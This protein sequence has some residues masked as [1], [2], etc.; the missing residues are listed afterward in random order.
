[1]SI[2]NSM[3][4]KPAM[5]S[6]MTIIGLLLLSPFIDVKAQKV[7]Q[8]KILYLLID[9]NFEHFFTQDS[10]VLVYKPKYLDKDG[11]GERTPSIHG[12]IVPNGRYLLKSEIV[13]SSVPT[14][15]SLLETYR[16][17]FYK[18]F[19]LLLLYQNG[20]KLRIYENTTCIACGE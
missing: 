4:P 13:F 14:A 6:R 9:R 15:Y 18:K 20:N 12:R 17:R 11:T 8:R 3:K 1:M 16:G 7:Q 5:I 10:S 19:Q 2:R